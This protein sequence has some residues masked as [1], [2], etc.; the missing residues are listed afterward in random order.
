[1]ERPEEVTSARMLALDAVVETLR[2]SDVRTA[3][4]LSG[5]GMKSPGSWDVPFTI[6]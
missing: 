5:F 2:D 6:L 3:T 1:M 4:I